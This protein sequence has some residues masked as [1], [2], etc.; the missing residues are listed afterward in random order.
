MLCGSG[1]IDITLP[2]HILLKGLPFPS[3]LDLDLDPDLYAFHPNL[4]PNLYFF[5]FQK[6]SIYLSKILK[7]IKSYDA[8]EKDKAM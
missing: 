7:T 3:D 2:V 4:K 5:G 1:R 8:D 6:I